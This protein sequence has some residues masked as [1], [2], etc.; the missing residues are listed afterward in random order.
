MTLMAN[1]TYQYTKTTCIF[2]D[3]R[4]A[5]FDMRFALSDLLCPLYITDS[6]CLGLL[7]TLCKS[8]MFG[9]CLIHTCVHKPLSTPSY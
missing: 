8:K 4:H 1:D 7:F 2:Q 3:I 5:G 9:I 6:G